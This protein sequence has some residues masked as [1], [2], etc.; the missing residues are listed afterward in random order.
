MNLEAINLTGL[1]ILVIAV[2]AIWFLLRVAF[3]LTASLLRLGC[4]I[5]VLV[6]VAYI[7]ISILNAP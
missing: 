7:V 2:V 6:V 5:G 4:L 3:R 1:V